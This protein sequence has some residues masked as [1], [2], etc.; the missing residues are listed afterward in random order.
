MRR[1]VAH[2]SRTREGRYSE[3]PNLRTIKSVYRVVKGI[4][5]GRHLH[6]IRPLSRFSLSL[7]PLWTSAVSSPSVSVPISRHL[8]SRAFGTIDIPSRAHSQ[9]VDS[10]SIAF[11]VLSAGIVADALLRESTMDLGDRIPRELLKSAIRIRMRMELSILRGANASY[12]HTQKYRYFFLPLYPSQLFLRFDH[13]LVI[14]GAETPRRFA[15]M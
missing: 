9:H 15:R 4:H 14:I 8:A 10:T 1:P 12:D 7:R 2:A 3:Q 11:S 6:P 5:F 13:R